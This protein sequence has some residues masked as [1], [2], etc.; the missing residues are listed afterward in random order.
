M[1]I[2]FS[3]AEEFKTKLREYN[4]VYSQIT[5][6]ENIMKDASASVERLTKELNEMREDEQK[7]IEKTRTELNLTTVELV[8]A[9]MELKHS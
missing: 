9:L 7:W 1:I 5:Q 4:R 8:N 6:L 3:V 2:P